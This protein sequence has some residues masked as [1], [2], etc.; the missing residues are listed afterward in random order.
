MFPYRVY[1][2]GPDLF[3][4]DCAERYGRLKQACRFSGLVGVSPVDEL[5]ADFTETVDLA[6]RIYRHNMRLLQSCDAVLAN[7]S[8]FRGTEPDS[9]TLFE[10]AYAFAKGI[11]V[12]AYTVDGLS[13]AER[14]RLIRKTS[15]DQDGTLRDWSDEGLIENFG[16]PLNLMISCSFPV[17]Q[18]PQQA[19][20]RLVE[21][22]Q[23]QSTSSRAEQP[24][25]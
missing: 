9:G 22:L 8:A 17:M 11:P 4:T 19:L 3:F 5:G 13:T 21:M 23:P 12:V 16:L 6:N 1:L 25:C 15:V 18:T 10:A 24:A 20:D 2:A 14:H 7:L